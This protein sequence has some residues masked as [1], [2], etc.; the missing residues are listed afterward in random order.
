MGRFGEL[1]GPARVG[2]STTVARDSCIS[3]LGVRPS[4]S[5]ASRL[6]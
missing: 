2:M 3:G 4:Q 1:D 5:H 6:R